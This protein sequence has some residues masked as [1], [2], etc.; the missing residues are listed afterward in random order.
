MGV[1]Y[2]A[3]KDIRWFDVF[4]V[5]GNTRRM[6]CVSLNGHEMQLV[7]DKGEVGKVIEIPKVAAL[8]VPDFFAMGKCSLLKYSMDM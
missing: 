7:E 1:D 2:G 5:F 6:L 3:G 8:H 4:I